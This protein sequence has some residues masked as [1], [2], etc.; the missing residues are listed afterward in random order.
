MLKCVACKPQELLSFSELPAG[1]HPLHSFHLGTPRALSD[2]AFPPSGPLIFS[3]WAF[4]W[5]WLHLILRNMKAWKCQTHFQMRKEELGVTRPHPKF[6][7]PSTSPN[8]SNMVRSITAMLHDSGTSLSWLDFLLL[9]WNIMTKASWKRKGYFVYTSSCYSP[10][11]N[12]DIVGTQGGNLK[13]GTN[14]EAMEKGY[15][16]TCSSW[17][18]QPASLLILGLPT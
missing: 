9:W 7:S 14:A 13:A 8:H 11:S 6:H 15:L 10:L 4:L 1:L 2:Q 3:L 16:L 5:F 17:L 18:A 12:Y